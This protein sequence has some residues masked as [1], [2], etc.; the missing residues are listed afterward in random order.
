MAGLR[1]PIVLSMLAACEAGPRVRDLPIPAGVQLA[2]VQDG[3][4]PW[5]PV[6]AGPYG[7]AQVELASER[8]AYAFVCPLPA[9]PGPGAP[10]GLLVAVHYLAVDGSIPPSRCAVAPT[11]ALSVAVTAPS[12]AIQ[13]FA[14]SAEA[15][16]PDAVRVPP[17][18]WDVGVVAQQ[19]AQS[20]RTVVA[21]ERA[22]DLTADRALAVDLTTRGVDLLPVGAITVDR[23]GL[24]DDDA[25]VTSRVR[26]ATGTLV[27]FAGAPVAD[28]AAPL[29]APPGLLATGDKQLLTVTA[30]RSDPWSQRAHQQV[31]V[32]GVLQP[33]QLPPRLDATLSAT[34]V[35][36]LGDWDTVRVVLA[37]QSATGPDAM[38]LTSVELE[39][40]AGWRDLSLDP[41]VLPRLDPTTL[42]GWDPTWAPPPTWL[43]WSVEAWRGHLTDELFRVEAGGGLAL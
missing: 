31:V 24:V 11:V 3:D 13:V 15:T 34:D 19:Y 25:S 16:P 14:A 30:W 7:F 42:P 9:L 12:F 1:A 8:F 43:G 4:G 36:W 26:L 40:S 27:G 39:A 18:V 38:H 17:G 32:D 20:N 35:R 41:N 2:V 23:G 5:R 37:Y 29:L 21:V 22:V 6:V 28:S 10:T 33:F